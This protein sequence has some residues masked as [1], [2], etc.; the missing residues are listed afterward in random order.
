MTILFRL[1]YAAAFAGILALNLGSLASRSGRASLMPPAS[2]AVA[3][4]PTQSDAAPTGAGKEACLKCHG[5]F[6]KLADATAKYVA[7][8]GETTTP[9][10]YVPHKGE[11]PRNPPECGNCHRTHP[12]PPAESDLAALVKPK[13]DWC[14]TKCHHTKD[15]TPC[16]TCHP[17]RTWRD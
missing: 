5:P 12:V 1:A 9:H 14:Y 6:D 10:R 15:F 13:V 4:A 8:S 3:S 2:G 11:E 17:G 16:K 7:P